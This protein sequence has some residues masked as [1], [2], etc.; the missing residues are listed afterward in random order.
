[1][2]SRAPWPESAL[3]LRF[4]AFPFG[5]PVS[6][7]PGN[8]LM[9]ALKIQTLQLS[10]ERRAAHAERFGRGRDVAIG[11][12]K[13]PLQHPALGGGEV[14]GCLPRRSEKIGCRQRFLQGSR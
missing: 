4:V 1:M 12:R 14:L 6:T 7:F 5:K 2:E 10:I 8:A 13:G 11:A 3:D 9:G